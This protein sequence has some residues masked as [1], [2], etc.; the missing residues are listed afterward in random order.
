MR[1]TFSK[2]LSQN[3][4]CHMHTQMH[5]HAHA[6]THTNVPA[7]IPTNKYTQSQGGERKRKMFLGGRGPLSLSEL[8]APISKCFIN[9]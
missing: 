8:P 5:T 4:Q 3:S 1:S 7:C 2:R 9:T 6:H